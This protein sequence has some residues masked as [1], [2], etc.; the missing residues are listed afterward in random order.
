MYDPTIHAKTLARQVRKSDF[1]ADSSLGIGTNLN[2]AIDDAVTIG[3]S[4]FGSISLTTNKLRGKSVYQLTNLSES[5]VVRH[6]TSNIRRITSVKQDDRQF[7][8]SCIQKM[9]SEG[10]AFRVYKFDIASFYESVPSQLILKQLEADMA[11]SGQSI[12]VLRSLFLQLDAAGVVGLP[13]GMSLSATLAE[14]LLRGFDSLISG[15]SGVWF[16][17]RFVDDIVIIT[18]GRE[19]K[20]E[21]TKLAADSLPSGL[22]FNRKSTSIDFAPFVKGNVANEEGCFDF[23]GYHFSVSLAHRNK[24]IDDKIRRVAWMDIA[25]S[26]VR[27]LKTRLARSLVSYAGDNDFE[28]LLARFRLLTSNFKFIDLKTGIQRSSGIYFNYP[29]VD[30]DRSL[31]LPEL[32]NYLVRSVTSPHPR[33]RLRPAMTAAQRQR[34]LNLRFQDGFR[35]R[36]FFSFSANRLS[37]LT[38]CWAYA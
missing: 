28:T 19:D 14:Y 10:T 32:D 9:A 22:H 37:A 21:F 16:Y 30:V 11:F 25:P 3:A 5:L 1:A 20:V 8:V 34:L 6:I 33:N 18:D 38:G 12:R 4:G 7:I 31:A 2:L 13:R 26:K 27:K 15:A 17:A 29:L 36:R 24:A 23:L 35:K